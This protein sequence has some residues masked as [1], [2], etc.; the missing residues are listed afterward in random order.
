MSEPIK[1]NSKKTILLTGPTDNMGRE[2]LRQL[3]AQKDKYDLVLF[4]LP[5]PKD[6]KILSAYANR[7]GIRIIWGDLTRYEDVQK[8]VEGVDIILHLGALVSPAADA[9]PQLAWDINYGGTKN[10]V[11][12]VLSGGGGENVQFV[13]IGTVAETGN[14]TPPV[15]WGRIGDPL[16]PAVY[17]YYALSKIAA[18]RYVIESG[19][20]HWV[21]L[22]QTGMLHDDIFLTHNG[23]GFHQ[24]L[25][26]H[27]EWVSAYDTGRLLANICSKATP[28]AFWNNV[29]NIG[30]GESCRLTAL[31]FLE[32]LFR[33]IGADIR[34]IYEP[35]MFALRNFHGQFYLDS[36]LLND[37]IPFRSQSVDD[38]L[39][40]MKKHLPGHIKL[41]KYLPK[42][43]VKYY[44]RRE[45]ERNVITPLCWIKNNDED[46]IRAFFGSGEI[47]QK[48]GGWDT[49]EHIIDPPHIVLNHGY[50]ETKPTEE[51]CLDDMQQAAAYRGGKCLSEKMT[52]GALFTKLNWQCAEGHTF[53]ASPY[54]V[55]K[56]GHWCDKCLEAP[57]NF[58]A[59]AKKNPF[60]AQVWHQDHDISE[61]NIYE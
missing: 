34:Q 61:N 13:Y 37:L 45:S 9:H 17:D 28:T 23:I 55:L 20:K 35:N 59:Q 7:P 30:G 6:K 19:L 32:K 15:H 33:L 25:N 40:S 57:W 26:N 39:V 47:W 18:E 21:S 42:T 54:L 1:P 31:Q 12:A 50:N 24:P 53:Q 51:W 38:T 14:R 43:F 56:A 2:A 36:D 11:D 4:A 29:Y 10:L 3:C 5:T 44:L 48:I 46:K 41:L 8:T 22:R 27:L 49:F 60:M 16:V 52:T 58:D